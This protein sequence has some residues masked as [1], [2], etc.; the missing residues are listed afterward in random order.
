M[1]YNTPEMLDIVVNVT[2]FYD[3][4]VE[5]MATSRNCSQIE[6]E[7]ILEYANSTSLKLNERAEKVEIKQLDG[8]KFTNFQIANIYNPKV[9]FSF[10]IVE[11]KVFSNF[12]VKIRIVKE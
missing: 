7:I 8:V 9:R 11:E 2:M 10:S 12:D 3:R 1:F 4:I 5:Y 6:P